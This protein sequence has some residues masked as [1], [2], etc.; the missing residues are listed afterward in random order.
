MRGSSEIGLGKDTVIYVTSVKY[1]VVGHYN[2][3]KVGV[4]VLAAKTAGLARNPIAIK[5]KTKRSVIVI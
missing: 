4:H 5:V 1:F 3:L 2:K